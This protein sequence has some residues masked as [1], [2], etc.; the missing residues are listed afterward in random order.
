MQAFDA[1]ILEPESATSRAAALSAGQ[2]DEAS[3]EALAPSDPAAL[4][5]AWKA[6]VHCLFPRVIDTKYVAV[7]GAHA[8]WWAGG[9][10]S[11]ESLVET[12][13]ATPKAVESDALPVA[14]AVNAAALKS[15]PPNDG[16]STEESAS[17]KLKLVVTGGRYAPGSAA[18]HEAG[19][20][21]LCT[22]RVLVRL[23]EA[24]TAHA[25]GSQS[26]Q[27]DQSGLNN[28]SHSSFSQQLG[29]LTSA[30]NALNL[31]R[32]PY[33]VSLGASSDGPA[34]GE[35]N[36]TEVAKRAASATDSVSAG[37][38]EL[39]APGSGGVINWLRSMVGL[40][41]DKSAHDAPQKRPRP[42]TTNFFGV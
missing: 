19:W 3:Q 37:A 7:F 21:A 4:Y 35:R 9:P 20:D 40:E 15:A 41:S 33:V 24:S 36:A 25:Q 34:P 26:L 17:N 23:I 10:T 29:A 14:D 18:Y 32:S 1:P 27:A 42:I 11:L 30:R 31:M 16:G 22:G 6:R 13:D 38:R 12:F 5:E 8:E 28:H 39:A 2:G